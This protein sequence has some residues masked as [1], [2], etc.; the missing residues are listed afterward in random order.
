MSLE[1]LANKISRVTEDSPS[2]DFVFLVKE[3]LI[4]IR[5]CERNPYIK[6]LRDPLTTV[7]NALKKIIILAL[8]LDVDDVV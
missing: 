1:T 8:N 5:S 7:E 3:I 4:F 6:G 2:V